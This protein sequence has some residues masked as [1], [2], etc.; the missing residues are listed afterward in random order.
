MLIAAV[1]LIATASMIGEVKSIH[2]GHDD[3]NNIVNLLEQNSIPPTN[4]WPGVAIEE[5]GHPLVRKVP[6][7]SMTPA[8]CFWNILTNSSL[9]IRR[10]LIRSIAVGSGSTMPMLSA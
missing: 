7:L 1:I 6:A 8:N 9:S 2:G 3:V 4:D 10:D 5:I